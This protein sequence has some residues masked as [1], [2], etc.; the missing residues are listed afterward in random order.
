MTSAATPRAGMLVDDLQTIF[1]ARLRAIVSYGDSRESDSVTC[2]ALVAT[3]DV[4]DLEACARRAQGWHRH[5]LATPLI[6]P[7]SEF[8]RSLDA[9]PL[10]YS[11]I[12]RTHTPVYGADPFDGLAIAPEDLRRA[13]ET[14]VKSHLLHL[15]EEFIETGGRPQAV[16][17]LVRE[18]AP[19]F[20][21]L[22]RSVARLHGG[23]AGDRD[24]AT[25]EGARLAALP[26]GIVG[27]VLALEHRDRVGSTDPAR[28]FPQYLA[29]LERLAQYVDSWRD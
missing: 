2:L 5:G 16:G 1:G 13:C 18:S 26:D 24:A 27:D 6:L 14:Q 22:L 29:A 12:I 8:R 20:A 3:L 21:A 25:R 10:E 11:E 7:E 17:E 15:R 9:F 23:D 19:A 4:A 28:L